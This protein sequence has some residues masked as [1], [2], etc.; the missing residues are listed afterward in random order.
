M[1]WY[2]KYYGRA[3]SWAIT[4]FLVI[5]YFKALPY[6]RKNKAYFSLFG[7][8]L[9]FLG[10]AN[11]ASNVPSGGRFV[12]VASLFAVALIFLYL[13]HL[14][15][16]KIIKYYKPIANLA[17]LYYGIFALRLGA[18]VIGVLAILGNPIIALFGNVDIALIQLLK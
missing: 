15:P 4:G 12:A 3:L 17:F 5:F 16:L 8:T 6:L 18:D 11:I 1:R 2:A 7:F 10:M 9:L 14:P 13:Q